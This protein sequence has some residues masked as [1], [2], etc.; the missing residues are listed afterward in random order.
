MHLV[1]RSIAVTLSLVAALCVP[2]MVHAETAREHL[3]S[4]KRALAMA[5][6]NLAKAQHWRTQAANIRTEL[7]SLEKQSQLARS[8]AEKDRDEARAL[9]EQTRQSKKDG[10]H[11]TAKQHADNALRKAESAHAA[12]K[13]VRELNE[14]ARA[15]N[16]SGPMDHVNK[17]AGRARMGANHAKEWAKKAHRDPQLA[18]EAGT[19]IADADA[20]NQAIDRAKDAAAADSKASRKHKA[21]VAQDADRAGAAEKAAEQAA[22]KARALVSKP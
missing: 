1:P 4:S 15:R 10:T 19:V 21:G 8:R 20:A 7:G 22:N 16:P 6:A 17:Y 12:A 5:Q 3:E 18:R 13:K 9:L 2:T 11:A 14:T